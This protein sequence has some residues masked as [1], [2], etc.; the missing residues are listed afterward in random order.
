[1]HWGIENSLHYVKDVTF[2]ED[3]SKIITGNAPENHSIVRNIAINIFRENEFES[4]ISG[5]R[6]CCN[7][8][9]KLRDMIC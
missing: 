9:F 5:I 1:M 2:K 6:L 3:H 8:I 4:I 7:K